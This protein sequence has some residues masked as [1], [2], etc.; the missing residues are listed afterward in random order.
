M[1]EKRKPTSGFICYKL[2]IYNFISKKS[3]VIE[4]YNKINARMLMTNTKSM[5]Q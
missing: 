5:Q 1:F 3:T 2:H 4:N